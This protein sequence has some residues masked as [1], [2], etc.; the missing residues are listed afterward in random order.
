[1]IHHSPSMV[2]LLTVDK[3]NIVMSMRVWMEQ[4]RA[5]IKRRRERRAQMFFM[6]YDL[7]KMVPKE[8][9]LRK[10]KER[11]PA[12]EIGEK[13]EEWKKCLG[14]EGY[15]MEVGLKALFLQFWGDCS[16]REM[17]ERLRYDIS[18][19]WFCGFKMEDETPDHTYF[20]RVRKSLGEKWIGELFDKISE[21]AALK[22]I[23]KR[24][25]SFVDAS[26]IRRKEAEWKKRD[27]E[28]E[29]EEKGATAPAPANSPGEI[30]KF[31]ADHEARWGCKGKKKYWFGYKRH[32]SVDTDS[33]LIEKVWTTRANVND[34]EAF[35]Y[36][37]PEGKRVLADRAYD[38]ENVRSILKR[39]RCQ[40]GVLRLTKRK[41]FDRERNKALSK[42]RAPWEH[43]FSKMSK[44]TRYMGLAKTHLQVLMEAIVHN[45]KR[46]VTLEV[47]TPAL[48]GLS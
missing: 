1:M 31:S 32:V 29:K 2:Y 19:R 43:V 12:Q 4:L 9:A 46:L 30:A 47:Q 6:N 27:E 39:R 20:C 44:R 26:A 3:N 33:G 24:L 40:D 28:R 13:R 7:E 15:G 21:D 17:E 34:A 8:H 11:F 36:V 48:I 18:Y 23:I 14:R 37:C 5:G 25:G 41:D 35:K 42:Q 10:V 16:D 38:T 22:Q 45:L